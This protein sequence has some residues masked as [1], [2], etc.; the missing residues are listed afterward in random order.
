[1]AERLTCDVPNATATEPI[2]DI[3]LE[4]TDATIQQAGAQIDKCRNC[5]SGARPAT[6]PHPNPNQKP[7]GSA[8]IDAL[9]KQTAEPVR[10]A[11]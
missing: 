11:A 1:M 8:M 7:W 6:G 3:S 2:S 4:Q 5:L 10:S 9:L